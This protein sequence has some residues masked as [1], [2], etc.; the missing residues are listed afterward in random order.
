MN[1]NNRMLCDFCFAELPPQ[2][3]RCPYCSGKRNLDSYPTSLPEGAVLQGRYVVGKVLGKGGFG[4]TYLCYDLKESRRVAVKEYLPDSLTHRNSGQTFVSSYGGQKEENFKAGA[5]KFYDEARLVSRFNGNPNIIGVYEFFFE[6]NTTYFVMEYLDGIDLKHYISDK[7]GTISESEALYMLNRVTEA[8]MIVHSAG[9]LHRDISPDNIFIGY[10]KTVKLIDFGAARQVVGEASQS[11]SVILKQGFAPLEQYQKRGHQGP[12]TDIYALGATIYY[13]LTGVIPD[14]AMSRLEEGELEA[15][16]IS[17]A[18]M[19]VLQKMLAVSA[20]A[21]YQ[22]IPELKTALASL[23]ITPVEPI[24][25]RKRQSYSF[26][27]KCGRPTSG[28]SLCPQCAGGASV[29]ITQQSPQPSQGAYK[30][31]TQASGVS[32]SRRNIIIALCSLCAAV[33]VAVT[34]IIVVV[35]SSNRA[36]PTYVT[37]N[38]DYSDYEDDDYD[39]ADDHSDTYQYSGSYSSDGVNSSGSA[40]SGYYILSSVSDGETTLTK[41]GLDGAGIDRSEY[42]IALDDDGTFTMN[43]DGDETTGTWTGYVAGVTLIS[44]GVSVECMFDGV[45]LYITADDINLTYE[46]Q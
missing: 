15:K 16:G 12:W 23:P 38:E 24:M 18:F 19:S 5:K 21:R 4:I 13:A 45:Y 28:G 30:S 26:C 6:N 33:A 7:G 20:N 2:G 3:G 9:V 22:N 37:D 17:P 14:D 32:D 36:E 39:Y 10:D 34:V 44:D 11:L 40:A 43:Y 1:I 46:K 27:T 42:W 41:S 29:R 35:N 31:S 25:E 8:L